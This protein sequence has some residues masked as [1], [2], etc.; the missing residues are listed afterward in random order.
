MTAPAAAGAVELEAVAAALARR[1]QQC[2]L[3]LVTAESCTG[4]AMAAA[5]TAPAGASAWFE[6]GFVAYSNPAKETALGVP[7]ALMVA[8]GAVSEPVVLAMAQ[9]ALAASQADVAIAASGVSGPGGGTAAKPVGMVCVAYARR[10]GDAWAG[11]HRFSG[12]RARIR[13]A[14]VAAALEGLSAWLEQAR[15]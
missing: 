7:E 3:R 10:S 1:L 9:G 5:M 15:A 4:G 2:R 11:T 8:H 6:R 13:A 12:D 14:T